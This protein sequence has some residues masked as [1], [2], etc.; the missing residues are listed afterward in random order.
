MCRNG[1]SRFVEVGPGKVL[2]GLIRQIA[3]QAEVLHA[4]DSESLKKVLAALEGH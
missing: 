2:R 1:V 4:E 3:P